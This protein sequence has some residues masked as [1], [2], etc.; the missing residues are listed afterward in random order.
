MNI[1][2]GENVHYQIVGSPGGPIKSILRKDNIGDTV[3]TGLNQKVILTLKWDNNTYTHGMDLSCDLM[4][5]RV[6]SD[7]HSEEGILPL[8]F[9]P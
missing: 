4:N 9:L 7:L 2:G 5:F 6:R 3:K 8:L 1:V